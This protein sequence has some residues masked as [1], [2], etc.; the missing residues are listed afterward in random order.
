MA[1]ADS[2][3]DSPMLEAVGFPGG[4][5]PRGGRAAHRQATRMA[6]SSTGAR[7][8]AGPAGR[9]GPAIGL[10]PV[11]DLPSSSP[12][13]GGQFGLGVDRHRKSDRLEHG[14]VTGGVRVGHRLLQPESFGLG[15]VGQDQGGASD[16]RQFLQ[17]SG[18]G[19]VGLAETSADDVVE[20][21]T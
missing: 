6:L 15:V 7:P 20:Q 12:G 8:M 2:A 21:R 1:Y 11:L 5:Q 17:P 4:G 13:D 16:G 19:A 10:A 9:P 3:N 18:E 14:Q